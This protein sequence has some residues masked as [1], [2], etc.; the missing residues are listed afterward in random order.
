MPTNRKHWGW[1]SCKV[2]L[3][4]MRIYIY[5]TYTA[6]TVCVLCNL[7]V[8]I[9]LLSV[10]IVYYLKNWKN[11]VCWNVHTHTNTHIWYMICIYIHYIV[12]IIHK[13]YIC[14]INILYFYSYKM[15]ANLYDLPTE[16]D[17]CVCVALWPMTSWLGVIVSVRQVS[18]HLWNT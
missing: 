6:Y 9:C 8:L 10:I 14:I 7:S 16:V 1:D 18:V 13:L 15:R 5:V 12:C 4:F 17:Q 2:A 11:I 3:Y